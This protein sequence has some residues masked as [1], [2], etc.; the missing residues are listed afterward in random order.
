MLEHLK[1]KKTVV[2]LEHTLSR[3][4]HIT[5]LNLPLNFIIIVIIIIFNYYNYYY[6]YYY[7]YYLFYYLFLLLLL[8]KD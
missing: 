2:T 6:Y 4:A 1:D 3:K 8:Q 7:Y 5:W